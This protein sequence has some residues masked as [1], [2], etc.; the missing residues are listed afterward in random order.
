M[1]VS[2]LQGQTENLLLAN[3]CG[4]IL[5]KH[6]YD[7]KLVGNI[8]RSNIVCKNIK[9]KTIFVVEASSYQLEYS[10]IFQSKY[11]VILNISPDHLERHKTINKYVKSKIKILNI[12]QK[13]FWFY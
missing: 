7:V 13:L 2:Q 11:A 4:K 12:I 5:L 3:F 6:K 8:G 10:Q 9:P 1:I